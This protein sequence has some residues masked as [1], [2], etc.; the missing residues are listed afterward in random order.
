VRHKLSRKL[1]LVALFALA[2]EVEV[3]DHNSG[4][5]VGLGLPQQFGDGRPQ[6]PV[7]GSG[8]QGGQLHRDLDRVPTALA[9]GSTTAP[10]WCPASRSMASTGLWRSP[11]SGT[12]CRAVAFHEGSTYH[13]SRSGLHSPRATGSLSRQWPNP[14]FARDMGTRRRGSP[15]C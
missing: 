3:L 1:P 7:T 10:A 12:D 5:L 9:V 8:G 14:L 2:G 11:A 15:G 4:A 13:R 6:A